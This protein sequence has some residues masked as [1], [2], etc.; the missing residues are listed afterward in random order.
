MAFRVDTSL[1]AL[2]L[3]CRT[4]AEP[5]RA[6]VELSLTA[7]TAFTSF[8]RYAANFVVAC[9]AGHP[10]RSIAVDLGSRRGAAAKSPLF[11][12]WDS[13]FPGRMPRSSLAH[14]G[15]VKG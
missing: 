2:P 14:E 11:G 13:I 10:K 6:L 1:S 12:T 4:Q 7:G 5:H 8:V 15:P 9:S 3:V